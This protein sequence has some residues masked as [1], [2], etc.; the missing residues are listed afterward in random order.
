MDSTLEAR[1]DAYIDEVWD[2]VLTDIETLVAH[3]SVAD[4]G[5]AAPGAPGASGTISASPPAMRRNTG[6]RISRRR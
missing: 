1:V 5:K 4:E 3:P 6:S 2:D